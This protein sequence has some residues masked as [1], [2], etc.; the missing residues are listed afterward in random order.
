[1]I[2][3][4]TGCLI[5]L[6]VHEDLLRHIWSRQLFDSARLVTTDGQRVRV[7][8]SGTLHRGSG[9]DFHDAVI[10]IGGTTYRGDVEFHRTFDD[11]KLHSHSSDPRYNSVVLHVVLKGSAKETVSQSG[12]VIPTIVL[13]NFLIVSLSDIE[14][15]LQREEYTTR[16]K[17]I[18]CFPI[19]DD[20]NPAVLSDLFQS[21]YRE[22]VQQKVRR[23]YERL[24]EIA[25][26]YQNLINEPSAPYNEPLEDDIPLPD[27]RVETKLLQQRRPWEQLLYEEVMEALGYSNNRSPMKRLAEN[28]SLT[29]LFSIESGYGG[30]A[31]L[32]KELSVQEIQAILFKGSGLLPSLEKAQSQDS[33]V[34]IHQLH[35]V[36]N[37]LSPVSGFPMLDQTEWIFSPTRPS[38]FP[39]IRIAAAAFFLHNLLYRSLFK[40]IITI[41][42][43]KYSSPESKI[44]QLIALHET[45]DD[46]FWNFHYS[47]IEAT[48]KKHVLLGRTRI[49]DIL[50]NVVVPFVS[51]YAGVFGKKD[52]ADHCLTIAVS[53]PLLDDNSILRQMNKQL[54]KKKI[55][56]DNAY[57]QQGILQLY[58]RYCVQTRCG[59]CTIGKQLHLH[60]L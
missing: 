60:S 12:R 29:T 15:H 42:A 48:H 34:Y 38:N 33:K 58:K 50:V 41:V 43:G 9:P 35:T 54:I 1:M 55:H 45:D 57:Q 7:V 51:L 6:T 18:K 27:N 47:F 49:L 53:L 24:C 44:D 31:G 59:E 20:V 28:V 52:L 4:P 5:D 25:L 21:M 13:E 56:I 19:N 22:R 40:S 8:H 46:P 10:E 23:L 3:L 16:T 2:L 32:K 26:L 39:T 30:S 17:Q 14:D 37:E 36:M 11:W